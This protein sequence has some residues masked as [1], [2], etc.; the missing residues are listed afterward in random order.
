MTRQEIVAQV[1]EAM[2]LNNTAPVEWTYEQ[3]A[4]YNKAL[5]AALS[6]H[7]ELLSPEGAALVERI[8]R[9]PA[10][11][12]EDYGLLD[13]VEDFFLEI[14]N[15]AQEINPLSDRN[16]GTFAM[17]IVLAVLVYVG[18]SAWNHSRPAP[19]SA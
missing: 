11:A 2:G 9:T 3:R 10:Q 4:A 17:V 19:P 5:A 1:R 16:R 13:K 12:L 14:E 18:V 15:Q 7:L 8:T 6:D